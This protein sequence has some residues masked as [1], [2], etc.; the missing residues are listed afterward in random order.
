M[1]QKKENRIINRDISQEMRESY[2]D[3]AMSVI[4]ARALPDVRDGLKP[5][6]RKILYTMH[7]AGLTHSAKFLK[8]AAI[9]GD[10]LGKY[11]PHGDAS[12]YD[13][14]AR[15]AQDFLMRYPLVDGQ[16]NWGSVDGDSPAAMRYT[17]ARMTSIAEQMLSDINKETVDFKP[18][19]DNRLMEPSVLPA[20]LP[21]LLVNGSFGI[22]V[23]MA[24]SI[25][26]H[27]LREVIDA[28]SHLI[29]NPDASLE[30]LMQFVK[31]PD[32]PTGG[33]IFNTK[34]IQ[35]AYA[36]GRG[37]VVMRGEAEIIESDKSGYQIIISSIP[38]QVNKSELI[39]K[40][41][42][43]V[44]EKKVEGIRDIRDES[45]REEKVR[46]AIDLKTGTNPQNVL[47]NLYKFTDLEKTFHFN[48]IA[49]VDGIQPQVLRLKEILQYFISHREIVVKR[50]TQFDL[51][52][53]LDRAHILEGLKKA[54]DHI[55]AIIKT[56]RASEDKDDAQKQLMAKFKFSDRQAVAILE[57]KLQSLANLERQ[58]V[59]DELKEKEKL[60]KELRALLADVKKLLKVVQDELLAIREKYGDERRTKVMARA[61]KI[62]SDE[63]LV[64]ARD[65]VMVLTQGGYVKRTDPDAYRAQ[66]RG[67]VGVIDMETKEED[68]VNIFVTANTHD[69]LL[70][71]SDKGKVYQ[72][73]MHEL[74]EGKKATKGKSVMNFLSISA[75]EKI[76]SILVFPKSAKEKESFLMMATKN[77]VVKKVDAS[78]FKDVRRNGITA[79]RLEKGDELKFVKFVYKDDHFIIAT[80]DGQSVM[81]KESDV[82]SMGRAAAGV[83]G[84]RLDD[85]DEVIGSDTVSASGKNQFFLNMGSK[86]YG[87]K[88]DIKN[89]RIQNRGGSGIKTFKVTEKTGHLMVARII[90]QEEEELIAIS[91]K[92][93]VIRTSLAEIPS[94]GRQT[95]GVRIMKMRPDDSI[96]TMTCL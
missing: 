33:M 84:I 15:M 35:Q 40:M 78:N 64:E 63:D 28:T 52:K 23:G 8:S 17:E 5:V 11:H 60:I 80:K 57:M 71:F 82:R 58:R 79:I 32:F 91:L 53:A 43:L 4:V 31:G 65:Q 30:D 10:A 54:L 48:M 88:T 59:E 18:N 77:G 19:Y 42:D 68:F 27:N 20:S 29:E 81:F 24:T 14:M 92:G 49:L 55:D 12:V 76:T 95:Q 25:P 1:D 86:G 73:K 94:L 56:I 37:G 38:Y 50:R 83:R 22:A 7:Q 3:Y 85:K 67:G 26:P 87:K 36:T 72:V 45:D 41:A 96:A 61:A 44:R 70:F 13:A 69:D 75:D 16:G 66:K 39:I 9:V 90:G 46:I 93:Q 89:Y 51:N 2:I 47:N 21:Q 6:H 34:D 62:M 74:P